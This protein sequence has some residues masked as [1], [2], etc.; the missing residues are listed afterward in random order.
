[1]NFQK[2][3]SVQQTNFTIFSNAKSC[4]FLQYLLPD[5]YAKKSAGKTDTL[6]Q[7]HCL[8]YLNLEK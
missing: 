8:Q 2:M 4:C 7:I 6:F 5:M 1:M 3:L